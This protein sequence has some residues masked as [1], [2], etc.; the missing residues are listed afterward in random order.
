[1][2]RTAPLD[3]PLDGSP[4]PR[5]RPS[6]TEGGPAELAGLTTGA[7]LLA[8]VVALVSAVVGL[9]FTGAAAESVL[10]DPGALVRWG[11]PVA[12]LGHDLSAA[13]ALGAM[14][15]A[16]TAVRPGTAGWTAVAR[17]GGVAAIIWVVGAVSA[18]VL[19]GADFAGLSLGAPTFGDALAQYVFELQIGRNLLIAVVM[20]AV[21]A[22][23][24]VAVRTPVGAGVALVGGVTALVPLALTGHTA[25]TDLHEV[26]GTSWWMHL[27]GVSVWVGGLATLAVQ[28]RALSPQLADVAARYSVLAGWSFAVVAF[29]GAAN[30]LVRV[31]S[32]DGLRTDYGALVL[33]KS[34]A[35]VALGV[36]GWLHR[37]RLL[38]AV[39]RP[40]GRV[41]F[42]RLVAAELL[43]MGLASGVAVA[44][45]RTATPVPEVAPAAPTPAE[46]LTGQPLPPPL[47]FG[48][49]VTE[50]TPDVLW[51][52]VVAVMLLTYVRGVRRLRRRGDRWPVHR[53]VLWVLGCLALLYVTCGGIAVYGRTLFSA[54]MV[55]HMSLSMVAP[56]L[57]VFGAPVTLALRALPKRSDG[58]RGP[59]EWLLGLV[60]SRPLVFF[61]HPVVAAVV[62][63]GSMIAFYYTP[64]FGQ[65]LRTH[66]GHEL[67]MIHFL[68][69]GYLFASALV[70]IDP[71][72]KRIAHP[73][74]LLLLFATMGFH[75]F[76]GVAIIA[77]EALFEASWFSS[78]GWGI[79]V[80]ADQRTGGSI[81]WG[82]G[83][84]PTLVIALVVAVQWSRS[85]DREAK[86]SDRAADRDGDADLAE[87]NAMLARLGDR[88]GS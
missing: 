82:I 75:A 53:T 78:L 50:T 45:S 52:A 34:A 22:T 58:S 23:L 18:L 20:A 55:Q 87:Y 35:L 51:I 30:A 83:E 38:A 26:A 56:P 11:F 44:L 88:D 62:F 29:S 36:A 40:G 9:L 4:S 59:R 25:T 57:L 71:G 72:P 80:L 27:V 12:R 41:A 84:V 16:A 54:H 70:G 37:R 24:V 6:A 7:A 68:L 15:L 49:L 63:A 42:W 64:L 76:F 73:L 3:E 65:A 14:A 8:V 1:M 21:V 39:G 17:T 69:A 85:D 31:G 81:A 79:D 67:M 13:V 43:L 5:P 2:S 33:V 47:T 86:R 74:R 60:H 46:L 77:Q 19:G 28:N 48:R 10:A 32:L 66:L 61:S